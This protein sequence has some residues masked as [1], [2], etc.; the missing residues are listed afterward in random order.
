ML[1]PL[2]VLRTP[3]PEKFGIPRQAGLVD[4][5]A[6]LALDPTR[7]PPASVRGLDDVSHVWLIVVFR[8]AGTAPTVR[9]PRFGGN[10]RRGVFATRSPFRP[11]PLGLSLV[12]L[13]RIE[14]DGGQVT[15][16][17]RGIDL[18]DNTSVLDVKPYLPWADALP[19]ARGPERPHPRAVTL[20]TTARAQ[21]EALEAD[22]RPDL[23]RLVTELVAQD[24]RPAY[25]QDSP[26]RSY[27]MSVLDTNVRFCITSAGCL[28]VTEVG[29][30]E[31]DTRDA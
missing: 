31:T 4:V 13:E 21:L 1:A 10:E 16:H 28:H 11:N 12:A 18:L 9:P 25:H 2:G 20:A 5:A 6:T 30:R 26:D 27:G 8:A 14:I 19:D 29:P 23:L 7:C 15:L 3:F 17:L 24:P 22:G